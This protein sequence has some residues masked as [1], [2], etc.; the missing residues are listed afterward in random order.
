[1]KD[2]TDKL[3]ATMGCSKEELALLVHMPNNIIKLNRISNGL[4]VI[5]TNDEKIFLL[6][7]QEYQFINKL[8]KNLKCLSP[9]QQKQPKKA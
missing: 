4:Y 9:R 3:C 7:K 5:E 6:T 8:D 2:M 1:M